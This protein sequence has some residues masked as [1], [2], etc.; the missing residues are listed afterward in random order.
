MRS[1]VVTGEGYGL[2]SETSFILIF[3]PLSTNFVISSES[4]NLPRLRFPQPLMQWEDCMTPPM[5][6]GCSS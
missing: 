3:A 5:E 6:S 1:N 4:F 2:W